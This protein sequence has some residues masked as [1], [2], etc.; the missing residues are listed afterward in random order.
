LSKAGHSAKLSV[1]NCYFA[2]E[3]SGF[4]VLLHAEMLYQKTFAGLWQM[5]TL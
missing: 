3:S 5:A 2:H 4:P 1:A